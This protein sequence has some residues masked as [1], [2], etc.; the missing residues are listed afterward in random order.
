MGEHGSLGKNDVNFRLSQ[1]LNDWWEL[2]GLEYDFHD[3]AANWLETD[4]P[5][6]FILEPVQPTSPATPHVQRA[7]IADHSPI[8]AKPGGFP[9]V[10]PDKLDAFH[11]FWIKDRTLDADYAFGPRIAPRGRTNAQWMIIC[12]MPDRDDSKSLLTGRASGLM[13][14][15]LAAAGIEETTVYYASIL[16]W[17]VIDQNAALADL[18][19]WHELLLHHIDLVAPKNLVLLGNLPNIALTQNNLSQN[20]LK[21][22]FVNHKS[23]QYDAIASMHPRL[24]LDRPGLK[25]QAWQDWQFMTLE[26]R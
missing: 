10:L 8:P 9:S 19:K 23:V 13:N 24:L 2:A 11:S 21:K 5:A 17:H 18:Q 20:R 6:P 12:D 4:D 1:S 16:P 25:A 7:E 15:I 14:R 26:E 3:E 22:L